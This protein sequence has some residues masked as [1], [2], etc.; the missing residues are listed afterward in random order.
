M[1]FQLRVHHFSHFSEIIGSATR[2]RNSSPTHVIDPLHGCNVHSCDVTH[3]DK[4]KGE[5]RAARDFAIQ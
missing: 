4:L 1:R 5:K 2:Q 3:I